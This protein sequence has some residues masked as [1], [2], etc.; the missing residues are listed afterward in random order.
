MEDAL[1]SLVVDGLGRVPI[2]TRGEAPIHVD[3]VRIRGQSDNACAGPLGQCL[4]LTNQTSGGEAV[5]SR[6]VQV[7]QY[8]VIGA[9]W[10]CPS[11]AIS[12][13]QSSRESISLTTMQFTPMSSTR[14][15][16]ASKRDG[17]SG[18]APPKSEC[19]QRRARGSTQT[20][21]SSPDPHT[22]HSD[23]ST[24]A[25]TRPLQMASSS[26]VPPNLR[27]VAFST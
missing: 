26:P 12:A 23:A 2:H 8:K 7:D 16:S 22:D 19:A 21:R 24:M 5:Y 14:R 9:L 13:W 27:T 6:Q 25:V 15:T 17:R 1:Q 4:L 20:R 11:S 3:A 18:P 10:A